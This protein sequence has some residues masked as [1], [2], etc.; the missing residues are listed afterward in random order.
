MTVALGD[1]SSFG[2]RI[3]PCTKRCIRFIKLGPQY[4]MWFKQRLLLCH[5]AV[6]VFGAV[7]VGMAF[8]AEILGSHVLQVSVAA[9]HLYNKNMSEF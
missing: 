1:T 9:A 2:A 3:L 4:I 6:V 8:M 5:V 7:A